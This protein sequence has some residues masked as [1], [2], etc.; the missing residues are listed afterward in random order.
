MRFVDFHQVRETFA[1]KRVVIV[2]SGPSI[3]SLHNGLVDKHDVVV[4]VNSYKLGLR[5]GRRCDVHYSY[6][7]Q[8]I[9]KSADELQR[10]GV[11]LCMN[12]CPNSQPIQSAWH[13][14]NHRTNGI[15]FRRIHARRGDFWFCDTFV[16]D[17]ERLLSK[18]RLLNGHMPSTGFAAILDILECNPAELFLTGFDFFSSG[19]HNVNEKWR[20]GHPGDPIRHKPMLEFQWIVDNRDRITCDNALNTMIKV[21]RSKAKFKAREAKAA[22]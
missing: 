21:N 12:K 9:R 11:M 19:I 14:A 22:A 2:G 6:Y 16:P 18:M 8:A 10:D 15:D 20:D 1:G 4:R 3:L 13:I 5:Q 7:G 17:D